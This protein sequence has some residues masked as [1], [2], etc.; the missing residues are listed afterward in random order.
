MIVQEHAAG[1]LRE[2]SQDSVSGSHG[3][4]PF[5][6]SQVMRPTMDQLPTPADQVT[7]RSACQTKHNPM[8]STQVTL[9]HHQHTELKTHK[10]VVKCCNLNF[11]PFASVLLLEENKIDVEMIAIDNKVFSDL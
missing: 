5:R 7:L 9:L 10:I 1:C 2:S 8:L 11:I 4:H 6:G 3:E